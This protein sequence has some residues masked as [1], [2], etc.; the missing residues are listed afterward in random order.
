MFTGVPKYWGS[1]DTLS[2]RGVYIVFRF[3]VTAAALVAGAVKNL[4][5]VVVPLGLIL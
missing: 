3:Y 1:A 2:R 5:Y 4:F